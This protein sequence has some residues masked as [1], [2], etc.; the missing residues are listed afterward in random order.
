MEIHSFKDLR[1]PERSES[2]GRLKAAVTA[3][4]LKSRFYTPC[5]VLGTRAERDDA[6]AAQ[7]AKIP[8]GESKDYNQSCEV[9]LC[10]KVNTNQIRAAE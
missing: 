1:V 9:H 3:I 8:I 6:L 4:G 5:V 2:A 10:A 7:A